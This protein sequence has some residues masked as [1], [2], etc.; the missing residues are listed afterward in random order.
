MSCRPGDFLR[1]SK[2]M[3]LPPLRGPF[4]IKA[5]E[6][7]NGPHELRGVRAV[8]SVVRGLIEVDLAD[9]VLGS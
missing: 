2:I 1:F 8:E 9:Q 6:R 7:L 5:T 3:A 4:F